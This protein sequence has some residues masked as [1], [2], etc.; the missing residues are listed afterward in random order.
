MNAAAAL[1]EFGFGTFSGGGRG[2]RTVLLGA[3]A[4]TEEGGQMCALKCT[5][6]D[7]SA[8]DDETKVEQ[9]KWD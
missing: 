2:K 3:W 9:C 4:E 1:L 7:C 6:F 8:T 5:Q